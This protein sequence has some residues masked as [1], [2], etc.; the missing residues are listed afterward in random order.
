LER[1]VEIDAENGMLANEFCPQRQRMLMASFLVPG[2]C[3]QHQSPLMS[4]DYEELNPALTTPAVSDAV[5]LP[6]LSAAEVE[7]GRELARPIKQVM[8]PDSLPKPIKHP[9]FP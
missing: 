5:E 2:T 9:P 8:P 7:V 3:L 6:V 4:T 1:N